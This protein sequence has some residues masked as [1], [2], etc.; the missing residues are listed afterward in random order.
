[1]VEEE[2]A[3]E[4]AV[5]DVDGRGL[6]AIVVLP[7]PGVAVVVDTTGGVALGGGGGG[8]RL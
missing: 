2:D 3:E 4:L 6:A 5:V 1:M 8:A 7:T